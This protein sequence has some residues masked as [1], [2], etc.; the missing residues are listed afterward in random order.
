MKEKRISQSN[1]LVKEC[2]VEA[3][4]QL[5]YS[6]PLSSITISELCDKAGVSRMSFYR[7]YESKEEI[8]VKRLEEIFDEYKKESD[9]T[10]SGIFY[11][12]AHM[13][14]YLEYLYK[15][16]DFLKGL[17]YCGFG[18]IFLEMTNDYIC[19]KWNGVADRYTLSAFAGALYNTFNRWSTEKYAV[20]PT[21]LA[22]NLARI[23]DGCEKGEIFRRQ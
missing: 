23:F 14:H 2:I 19:N 6:K 10:A 11:D 22:H 1:I 15:Y 16:K 13:Q 3:L 4:L 18:N 8:F 12:E 21:E 5:L 17:V 7:N 9:D 20:N